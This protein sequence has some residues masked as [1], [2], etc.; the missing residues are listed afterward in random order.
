MRVAPVSRTVLSQLSAK[1]KRVVE[2]EGAVLFRRGEPAFGIFVVRKG[3]VA[4]RLESEKGTPVLDRTATRDSILGL[5][6]TLSG[7]RYSLTAVTLQEC[8]LAMIPRP[9]LLELI[10]QDCSIGMELM[11]ALGDEV[12]QMRDVLAAPLVAK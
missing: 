11:R 9:E 10:Q 3:K 8:E 6:G 5:P 7:G 1:A 2:P 4:L 12:V